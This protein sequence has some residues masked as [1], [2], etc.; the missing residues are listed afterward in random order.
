MRRAEIEDSPN[1]FDFGKLEKFTP[2][3]AETW[4]P[5]GSIPGSQI[6]AA[7][8]AYNGGRPLSNPPKDAPVFE[9]VGFPGL[10]IIPGLLPDR[11][12]VV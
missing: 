7:C 5:A 6:E 8:M 11:K 10:Q 9:H 3:Q 1:I 4:K 12:S 2:D